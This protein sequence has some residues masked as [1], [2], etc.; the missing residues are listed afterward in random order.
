MDSKI[1]WTDATWNPVV[2]CSPVSEGCR[3]CY[4]A[5]EA[6]RLQANPNPK[7]SEPYAGTS[8]M[9]GTGSARRPVFTGVVR[10]LPERLEQPLRWRKPQRIFVNSMSDL[11]HEDVPFE[12]VDR[13]FAVMAL[14][15]DHTFQI[16]T[17]RPER[18]AEYLNTRGR[19]GAI[20]AE[21]GS[22]VDGDQDWPFI[23]PDDLAD[24][25]PLLNCWMGTSVENQATAL[26]RIPHLIQ[27][28]A[29][30]RFLSC[31]PLLGPI[32][33]D[34]WL[35]DN[36]CYCGAR[37]F[38]DCDCF[39]KPTNLIHWLIAGGESGPAARPMNIEWIR[40]LISQCRLGGIAPFVKQLGARPHN[41]TGAYYDLVSRKGG[42]PEEW[43]EDL[44]VREFPQTAEVP[45]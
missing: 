2:G 35:W 23:R 6:I 31:E 45:A 4:A 30:V 29:A 42:D 27:V 26:E 7:V 10:C 14:S 39:P 43:P 18:M 41:A 15:P 25:W 8:E 44:R 36:G 34:E 37:G 19:A 17:K 21:T 16:L 20:A 9:R 32:Y 24:R 13:V 1:E 28:P 12:F 3:N 38:C 11:F 5:K 40:D 22:G 33:L